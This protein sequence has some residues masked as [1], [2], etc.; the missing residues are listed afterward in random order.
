MRMIPIPGSRVQCSETTGTYSQHP[1]PTQSEEPPPPEPEPMPWSPINNLLPEG[2][3][4]DIA[5]EEEL[6][7]QAGRVYLLW[8]GGNCWNKVR[9]GTTNVNPEPSGNQNGTIS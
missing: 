8:D 4:E 1:T 3:E 6:A 5:M 9:K 7:R 2:E